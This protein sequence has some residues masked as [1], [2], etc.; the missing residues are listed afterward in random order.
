MLL[1][2]AAMG[3][4]ALQSFWLTCVWL[5]NARSVSSSHCVISHLLCLCI[6][7]KCMTCRWIPSKCKRRLY[8]K[9]TRSISRTCSVAEVMMTPPTLPLS[10]VQ[11]TEQAPCQWGWNSAHVLSWIDDNRKCH[12]GR[13]DCTNLASTSTIRR[14]A[15]SLNPSHS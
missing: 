14:S 15:A 5:H 3:A 9:R 1:W 8:Q 6:A 10:R 4:I 11:M 7:L 12:R 13:G 2:W